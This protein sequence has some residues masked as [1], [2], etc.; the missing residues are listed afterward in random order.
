MEFRD[1][2][3]IHQCESLFDISISHRLYVLS[4][5]TWSEVSWT[6]CHPVLQTLSSSF[7]TKIAWMQ[8]VMVPYPNQ[9]CR[10]GMLLFVVSCIVAF[11][12]FLNK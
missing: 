11:F 4:L 5:A 3:E 7:F 2:D 6:G 12:F 8:M 10:P 9:S 1:L